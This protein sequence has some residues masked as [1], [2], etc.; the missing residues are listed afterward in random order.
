MPRSGTGWDGAKRT[1]GVKRHIAVD[2]TGLLLAVGDRIEQLGV[3]ESPG[4]T[5]HHHSRGPRAV[6][7]RPHP[8]NLGDG[9]LDRH[10]ATAPPRHRVSGDIWSARATED[11]SELLAF[12][13]LGP[14]ATRRCYRDRAGTAEKRRNRTYWSVIRMREV[15]RWHGP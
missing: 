2:V 5:P 10:R 14:T 8:G 7:H 12:L 13:P 4:R 6:V 3:V 11:R 1:T 15:A 9:I